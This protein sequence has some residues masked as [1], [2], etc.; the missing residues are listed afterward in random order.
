M[1][2]YIENKKII[3]IESKNI[4]PYKETNC[5]GG[6]F[7]NLKRKSGITLIALIITIIVLLILA[8]VTLNAVLGNGGIIAKAELAREK[9]NKARQEEENA[10]SEL[11]KYT[12]RENYEVSDYTDNLLYKLDLKQI[13]NGENGVTISD[14]GVQIDNNKTYATFDGTGE[15]RVKSTTVDPDN[16][17][18]GTSDKTLCA[19]YRKSEVEGEEGIVLYGDERSIRKSFLIE[20]KC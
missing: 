11:Y 7:C 1:K 15:I 6:C 19:W 3:N 20:F 9:T 12:T 4:Y 13:K 5:K 10:L 17:L 2:K 16:V 8:G 14:T 18:S